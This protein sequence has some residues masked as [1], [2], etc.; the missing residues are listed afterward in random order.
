MTCSYCGENTNICPYCLYGMDEDVPLKEFSICPKCGRDIDRCAYCGRELKNKTSNAGQVSQKTKL[1][2]RTSDDCK[3]S[4]GR[5]SEL[6]FDV[7]QFEKS[8]LIQKIMGYIALG[9][10][11]VVIIYLFFIV[12]I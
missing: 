9:L 12:H 6:K 3:D 11:F 7:K 1:K 10:I 5:E 8:I 2:N 4:Y